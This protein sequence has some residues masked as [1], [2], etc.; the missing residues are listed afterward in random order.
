M[1]L[2]INSKNLKEGDIVLAN[3]K[4]FMLDYPN[5]PND[6]LPAIVIDSF[7]S[8]HHPNWHIVSLKWSNDMVS[9]KQPI[10]HFNI[11]S[12]NHPNNIKLK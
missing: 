2:E 8:Q 7:R 12:F 11:V 10:E 5:Q 9:F 6:L 1:I 4:G 3:M